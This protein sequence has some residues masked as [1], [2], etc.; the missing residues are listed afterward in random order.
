METQIDANEFHCLERM[1]PQGGCGQWGSIGKTQGTE[2]PYGCLGTRLR[3][4]RSLLTPQPS[5]AGWAEAQRA[6]KH[7]HTHTETKASGLPVKADIFPGKEPACRCRRC[8]FDPWVG[9]TPWRRKW[10]PTPAFLPGE[11]HGQRSLVGDCPRDCKE[12]HD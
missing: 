3:G 5:A 4:A 7:T 1:L 11:S 6:F 8:R 2:Q 12:R 10:Q 9:K